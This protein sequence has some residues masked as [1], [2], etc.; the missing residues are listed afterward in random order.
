MNYGRYFKLNQKVSKV[1]DGVT[2]YDYIDLPAFF[3]RSKDTPQTP[4]YPVSLVITN[5]AVRFLLPSK[6]KRVFA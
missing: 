4:K 5:D 3:G 1:V 2:V 6:K